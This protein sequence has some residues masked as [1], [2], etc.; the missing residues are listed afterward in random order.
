MCTPHRTALEFKR[1]ETSIDLFSTSCMGL[2]M[3]TVLTTAEINSTNVDQ[4]AMANRRRENLNKWMTDRSIS[5]SAMA[6]KVERSRAYVSNLFREDRHF[7]EKAAR[8]F[9]HMLRMP[10]GYLDSQGPE[11][12]AVS[13][14]GD[15]DYLDPKSIALVTRVRVELVE[16][17]RVV[18]RTED[19][20]PPLAF[21]KDWLRRK[22]VTAQKNLKICSVS[23]N[24]MRPYLEDGDIVMIDIGQRDLKDGEVYAIRYMDE[25]RVKRM[26]K[27]LNG[28]RIHSDAPDFSDE[29]VSADSP[30]FE[31]IGRKIWRGG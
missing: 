16:G 9:E 30:D 25:I 3:T 23:D 15:P 22:L 7:G 10:P 5:R 17:A 26:F 31:I 11:P 19:H 21:Q 1:F 20:M 14:W 2:K 6:E 13:N 8:R 24:S 12:L 27:T 4:A 28:V 29:L 18:T